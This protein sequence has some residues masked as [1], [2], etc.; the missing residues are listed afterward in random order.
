MTDKTVVQGTSEKGISYP[1]GGPQIP[2][3]SA[4]WEFWW[5]YNHEPLVGLK[6]ALMKL[7]PQA[8]AIDFPYEKVTPKSKKQLVRLFTKVMREDSSARVRESA[9]LSLARTHDETV[10]PWLQIALE[11]ENLYVRTMAVIALGM[12]QIEGAVPVLES[13][14]NDAKKSTEERSYA[15]VAV[16][17]VGGQNA[18]ELFKKWLDPKVFKNLD[19]SLQQTVAFG[20]G[21]TEDP[22]L[23]PHIRTA[24]IENFS[25]DR[26]TTSYLVLSL[27]R[28][29][30]RA[31]NAILLDY[32]DAKD[33][34]VRR[35][36]VIALGASASP[37]D[38]D[39]IQGLMDKVRD[40]SDNI[41]KNFCFI[42]LGKIGGETAEAFL[43]TQLDEM[44]RAYLPYVGL[45]LGLT[46]NTEH[47]KILF[48]KFMTVKDLTSRGALAVAM[49]L[50]KYKDA[51]G[52]LRKIVDSGGEPVFN[53]YCALAL[54]ML[55][56]SE[57]VE[58]ILKLYQESNDV[59]LQGNAARALGLIGDL[60]VTSELY[61]MLDK[62]TPD[63]KR[64]STAYNLGLIGDQKAVEPLIRVISNKNENERFRSYALLG[65]GML[66]DDRE[67]PV[68]SKI[69]RNN[70]DT[71]LDNFLGELLNVN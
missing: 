31:A 47:G 39:V 3:D 35:S 50:L 13:V 33:T 42:S 8:G 2:F 26:I 60:S 66:G 41:M 65:L 27:G 55:R 28:L 63:I 70:N 24:L 17:L 59:E 22:T 11:D 15:A 56:D 37:S 14:F 51:I 38:K 4:R 16:G 1:G 36:A 49:G 46:G 18:V 69:S 32:M 67:S 53:G 40:D 54:G 45:A 12:S 62:S 71:I 23:G 68:V 20:V 6:S 7:T 25:D 57:S 30:D 52:E 5:D 10:L 29:G 61:K 21:L 9:L 64:L 48:A 43:V 19:R 58:R 34:Q 44:K